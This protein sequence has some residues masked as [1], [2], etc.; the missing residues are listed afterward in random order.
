MYTT[1]SVAQ[2]DFTIYIILIHIKDV[3]FFCKVMVMRFEHKIYSEYFM[4]NNSADLN[5][6]RG[7][8]E[9]FFFKH[10]NFF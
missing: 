1:I 4:Y 9:N 10:N 3:L 7:S 6:S 2:T 8:M 5:A